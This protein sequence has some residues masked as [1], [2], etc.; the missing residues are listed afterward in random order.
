MKSKNKKIIKSLKSRLFSDIPIKLTIFAFSILLYFLVNISQRDT[1]IFLPKL[2]VVGLNDYLTIS[3]DIPK[4]IKLIIKD[5]KKVL[6]KISKDDFNVRIDLSQINAPIDKEI[7]LKWDFPTTMHSFFSHVS[8]VPNKIKVKIRNLAEKNVPITVNSSGEIAFGYVL[9]KIIVN[10]K[11][12]RIKGPQ[13]LISKIRFLKTETIFLEGA[14]DSF[15]TFGKI[16]TH[17][18]LVN[19]IGDDKVEL[20]FEIVREET[21]KIIKINKISIKNVISQFRAIHSKITIFLKIKGP[22]DELK[23]LDTSL[24]KLSVDCSNLKYPGDYNMDIKVDL[25]NYLEMLSINPKI[26]KVSLFDKNEEINN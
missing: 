22:K 4:N 11:S 10:P 25:P 2:N 12:V 18:P 7:K 17:S 14:K 24:I 19:I 3:S 6:D 1:Q 5:K 9:K 8:I 26:I 20:Y 15:K 13:E 23:N 21:N 16:N